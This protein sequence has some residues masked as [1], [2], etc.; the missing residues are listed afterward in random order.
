ML[1]F[2]LLGFQILLFAYE[3]RG[4]SVE[5][6]TNLPMRSEEEEEEEEN[7]HDAIE[8]KNE[9]RQWDPT[10]AIF[11]RPKCLAK[12]RKHGKGKEKAKKEDKEFRRCCMGKIKADFN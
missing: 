7:V 12:A 1:F 5:E 8:E 10:C 3:I 6:V 11:F 4:N 9:K 2:L